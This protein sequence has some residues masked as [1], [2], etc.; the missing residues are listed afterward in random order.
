[1]TQDQNADADENKCEKRS[2]VGE[3]HHLINAREHRTD[4]D[5]DSGEDRRHM[6]GAK[7]RMHFR[8]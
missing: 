6:R 5:S 7:P 2:N 3:V 4:A 1:M 8:E